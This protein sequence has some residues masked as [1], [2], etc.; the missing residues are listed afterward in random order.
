M[1]QPISRTNVGFFFPKN[2]ETI[3][4]KMV[5]GAGLNWSYPWVYISDNQMKYCIDL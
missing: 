2:C 4:N 1:P 5:G 3:S